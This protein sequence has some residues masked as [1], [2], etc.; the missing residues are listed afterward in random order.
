[1]LSL[2]KTMTKWSWFEK[3]TSPASANI[4]W[5]HS[6]ARFVLR[7]KPRDKN[8]LPF[9]SPPLPLPGPGDLARLLTACRTT[10]LADCHSIHP[11]QARFG[12][13]KTRTHRRDLQPS[14]SGPGAPYKADRPLR[15]RG[16]QTS[17]GRCRYGGHVRPS[18]TSRL[19]RT[20]TYVPT[21]TPFFFS[22]FNNNVHH[23][24]SPPTFLA[25]PA[26]SHLC[27]TMRGVQKPGSITTTSCML[28]C[29]R[30]Q[31]KTR[32]EFLTLMKR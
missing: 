15:P 26:S 12:H 6:L 30:T 28:G 18:P 25:V 14:P 19:H 4:I 1:M 10:P 5:F 13:L 31:Q 32:E 21:A 27:M 17:W 22:P 2:R 16:Y 3:S 9:P 24:P 8:S 11:K 7:A 23:H 20:L 29:F